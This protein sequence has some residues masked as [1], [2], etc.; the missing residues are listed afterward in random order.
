MKKFVILLV[1]LC[2]L[3]AAAVGYLGQGARPDNEFNP[4]PVPDEE[5]ISSGENAEQSAPIASAAPETAE[6]PEPV[7]TA[8]VDYDALYAL[9]GADEIVMTID[10]EPI[11]WGEYFAWL[12]MNAMQI[13]SAMEQYAGYGMAINWTDAAT[14]SGATYAQYAVSGAEDSISQLIAIEG[15]AAALGFEKDEAFE[16]ELQEHLKGD[17][18][19]IAGEGATEEDFYAALDK[20][21]MTPEMYRRMASA[22]ALYTDAFEHAYGVNGA[23]MSDEEAMKFLED[24]GYLSA[25]HILLMTID[26]ATGEALDEAAVQEKKAQAE[27]L[28]EELA[29]IEDSEALVARFKEL[30]E[31]YCEDTG[32]TAY[33]DGYVFTPGTMVAEFEDAC[34][35]LGDYELSAP[36]ES[37]YGY[38]VILRLPLGPDSVLTTSTDG[39]EVTARFASASEEYSGKLG[40]YMNAMETEYAEGFEIPD[41]L[42]FIK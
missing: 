28:Y 22:N 6:T 13:E 5:P 27:T 40:A 12:K 7:K 3:F 36:V 42:E 11:R 19:A 26:P 16:N 9:H 24:A 39:S 41:L 21:G 8:K 18:E 20:A 2:L 35:A 31:Q 10:G 14:E 38:H 15:N 33:P 34:K 4:E 30:K 25:N 32:K 37:S 17:I 23:D 29:T 1:V